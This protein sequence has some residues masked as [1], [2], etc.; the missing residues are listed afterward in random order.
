MEPAISL[1]KNFFR[2]KNSLLVTSSLRCASQLSSRVSISS[3]RSSLCSSLRL[4]THLSLSK[5]GA[6]DSTLGAEEPLVE[7]DTIFG[8]PKK[9]VMLAFPPPVLIFLLASTLEA[10]L[11]LRV[12]D[13]V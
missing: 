8:A 4:A 5:V 2:S 11:R 7:E 12:E 13:M 10:A 6:G 9:D 3:W 1:A